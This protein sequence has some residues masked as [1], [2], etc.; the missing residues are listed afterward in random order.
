MDRRQI[1][2]LIATAVIGG[3][4]VWAV[5]KTIKAL[6]NSV[7]VYQRK[8]EIF[9]IKTEEEWEHFYVSYIQNEHIKVLG[10]DCEWVFR[11]RR[12]PVALLQLATQEG[13]CA[14]IRIF[15]MPTFPA[16]LKQLLNDRSILK[17]GVAPKDDAKKLFQDYGLFVRGCVDLRH[18]LLRV[19]GIYQCPSIGLQGV[20]Q[21]VLGVTISK[22]KSVRC[23]NWEADVLSSRQK[24][25]AAD[26][27]IVAVDIF[28]HLV[29]AKLLNRRPEAES[30]ESEVFTNESRFWR[31]ARSLCQG[32][33]DSQYKHKPN[34]GTKNKPSRMYKQLVKV[35]TDQGKQDEKSGEELD[36][37][38]NSETDYS[39][40]NQQPT[41]QAKAKKTEKSS[42][43]TRQRPLYDNCY[44]LAPDGELLCSCDVRKAAWYLEKGLAN[45]VEDSPLTVKLKFEPAGRPTD[46]YYLQDKENICVVCGV[47]E[48]Y[49][50]KCVIP[51][52][53]RKYLPHR[54]KE[55]SSHDVLLMCVPCHMES[56]QHDSVLRYQLADQCNAPIDNGS[57]IK[58]HLDEELRKVQSASKALLKS[59]D[60][61][62]VERRE[63]LENTIK[64][65]YDVDEITDE[66]L[67][68]AVDIDYKIRNKYYKPHG[69]RVVT[70]M[71]K[72]DGLFNFEKRWRQH[73][74]DTMKPKFMPKSWSVNHRHEHHR[75]DD[76]SDSDSEV[77]FTDT[78]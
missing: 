44:L 21:G 70:H 66:L 15:K 47:D 29:L 61:I 37:D 51:R 31:T 40:T 69:K 49:I 52:E 65:F 6:T 67:H 11:G 39:E 2:R 14:L 34:A 5:L 25:Y 23:G 3:V 33:V 63:A 36:E 28:T 30:T 16:S 7:K 43:M 74:L 64:S 4:G 72:N 19:R 76:E 26:D 18:M 1:S 68:K 17:V 45:K 32:V 41:L 13:V 42:Y 12:H 75:D 77:M 60:K 55:H 8:K 38:V 53:Y 62:P 71:K 9:V 35:L 59:R 10:F 22:D 24:D 58:L 27:A 57:G 50:R 56:T 20:A 46:D 73:F 48:S 78:I 54:L